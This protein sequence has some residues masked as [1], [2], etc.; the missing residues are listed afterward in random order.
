MQPKMLS[1]LE[2]IHDLTEYATE[3]A[4]FNPDDPKECSLVFNYLLGTC[5]LKTLRAEVKKMR[6]EEL[7]HQKK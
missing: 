6:A 2:Q 4:D 3:R 5:S 1:L 7:L